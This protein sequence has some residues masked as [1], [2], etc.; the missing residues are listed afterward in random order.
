MTRNFS[1]CA[2]GGAREFLLIG[3][4]FDA[5]CFARHVFSARH[6]SHGALLVC[7]LRCVDG[8]VIVFV[9]LLRLCQS[10]DTCVFGV[11]CH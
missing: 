6:M 5:T 3:M 4:V 8:V 2:C 7:G 1:W 10:F 11:V 9:E